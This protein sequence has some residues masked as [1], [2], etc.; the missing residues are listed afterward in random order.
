MA[1]ESGLILSIE[2][3]VLIGD[4]G[5]ATMQRGRPL[6]W[7]SISRRRHFDQPRLARELRNFSRA[8]GYDPRLLELELTESGIMH[9]PNRVLDHLKAFR[10]SACRR[11]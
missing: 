9:H 8:R 4:A 6:N 7:R 5:A 10:R 11:D 2:R 1:E 3:W